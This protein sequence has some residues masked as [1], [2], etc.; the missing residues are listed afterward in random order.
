MRRFRIPTRLTVVGLSITL[1]A[2]VWA[3]PAVGQSSAPVQG[4][5]L[6][7]GTSTEPTTLDPLIEEALTS[8][9]VIEQMYDTLIQYDHDLNFEPALAASWEVAPDS[10]SITFSLRDDVTFHSGRPMTSADVK[11]SIDQQ[12]SETNVHAGLYGVFTDIETPDDKTVVFRLNAATPSVA[13]STLA[14]APSVV[15]YKDVLD[16]TGDLKRVDAGTGP[17]VMDSWDA[18]SRITLSRYDGYWNAPEP[19]IDELVF[20]ILPDETSAVAALRADEIDWFQFQDAVV[21]SEIANDPSLVYTQAPFLSYS[22]VGMNTTQKPFD[23][24]RVRMA[25]SYALDRQEVLDLALE[26]LG[27]VTGPIV[28]AQANLAIPV[29]EYPSYTRD[30]DQ[31]KALLAEAGYADG[32]AVDLVI[33]NSNAVM[34]AAAP[35]VVDQLGEVGIDVSIVPVE[36]AIWLEHLQQHTYNGLIM[37]QSGGAPNPDTPLYNSFTCEGP[38]N[39]SGICDPEYD[40][41]ITAARAAVGDDRVAQYADIQRKL[42]NDMMPYAYLFVRDQ[43]YGWDTDVKGY[44]PLPL[45]ER[46]FETVSIEG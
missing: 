34:N 29:S 20:K 43:L 42:V 15:F 21:A 9:L 3:A 33:V 28:P 19:Y 8:Y 13:L 1:L 23:D 45:V 37:G 46:R 24:A 44:E 31:A 5:T 30:V 11:Y 14:V 25:L 17:F 7:V 26:G 18:G 16:A 22:Y 6:N 12:R 36:T 10:M 35:V 2:G 38:W 39:Y 4:G 41:M 32:F 27:S 40:E